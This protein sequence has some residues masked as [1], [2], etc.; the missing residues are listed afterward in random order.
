MI[1][2]IL[3]FSLFFPTPV[4]LL[5]LNSNTRIHLTV[6]KQIINIT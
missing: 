5:M 3:V 6:S 1:L 4:E 2:R